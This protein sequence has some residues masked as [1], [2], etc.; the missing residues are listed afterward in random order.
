VVRSTGILARM[1]P[2]NAIVNKHT[3]M[4]HSSLW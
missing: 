4:I 1:C 2:A 3:E